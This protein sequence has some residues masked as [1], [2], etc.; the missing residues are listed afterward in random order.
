ML[1]PS[2]TRFFFFLRDPSKGLRNGQQTK[3]QEA[4]G[5][6][7]QG[8]KL[9]LFLA[10][11]NVEAKRIKHYAEVFLSR[12]PCFNSRGRTFQ[13]SNAWWELCNHLSDAHAWWDLGTRSKL[14]V[15]T[16]NQQ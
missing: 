5:N 14:W 3:I 2:C 9:S 16:L 12:T 1:N 15:R 6:P 11:I 13:M 4:P 10:A 8:V 7:G